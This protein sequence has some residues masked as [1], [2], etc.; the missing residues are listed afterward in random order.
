MFDEQTRDAA[1]QQ[2]RGLRQR[3]SPAAARTS[4]R[5][6]RRS[7]RCCATSSRSMANLVRPAH[8]AR[9]RSSARSGSTAAQVA[10]VAE[11]QAALFRNLD[12]TFTALADG[13]AALHPGD[14]HR[15]R[16]PRCDAAIARAARSS[17]RSWPTARRFF[18]ELRPGVAALRTRRA[19]P[20]RRARRSARRRCAAPSRS[21]SASSRRSRRCS[22]SPRTRWSPL[23]V[24]DLDEHRARSLDPTLADLTPAQTVCNYV[25]LLVPQRRLAAERGRQQ[26]HV[27]ALHHRRHAAG[28]Q[29]RGRPVVGARQR[30]RP[31][32]QLPA[33][34]PVPE[35][36]GAGPDRTSARPATSRYAAGKQVIGNVPGNQGHDR[37]TKTE[38]ERHPKPCA[39]DA[40]KDARRVP[41]KDRHG[42]EPVHGRR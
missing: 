37:R 34:Q 20:G 39:P 29:Q 36:R 27:A 5:R 4:T 22:A 23:G 7:A 1:Q 9:P 2:P 13:R 21:T 38:R 8:A 33:H 3:A 40:D 15:R 24:Q 10:P 14:D 41:R 18:R 6:S 17:A 35:H 11:T 30:A 31:Q 32:R 25:T 28:P 19:G 12:T 26:R 16:R 42:R